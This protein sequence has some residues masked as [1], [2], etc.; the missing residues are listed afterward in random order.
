ME[1]FLKSGGWLLAMIIAVGGWAIGQYNTVID[2]DEEVKKTW[3]NVEGQYQRRADLIPNLVKTVQA[4]AD[5]EN[6]VFTDVTELRTKATSINVNVDNPESLQ[7]FAGAQSELSAW[8][9]RLL[10]VSE[11]YPD[12][13]SN[14][15]FLNLQTQL[16]G[17]ENRIAVARGQFNEAVKKY[18][19]KIRQFPINMFASHFNF[20]AREWFKAAEGTQ[21]VPE[22]DFNI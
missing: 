19:T 8:L 5:Q 12:L 7:Q 2:M 15:N 3:N 6:K 14:E 16:E 10:A 11:N 4:F 21:N 17:T 13:K 9:G 1:K 22:V 20:E 18:S